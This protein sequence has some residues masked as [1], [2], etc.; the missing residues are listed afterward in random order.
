M[1][2]ATDSLLW[3]WATQLFENVNNDHCRIVAAGTLLIV[4]RE[5]KLRTIESLSTP[6]LWTRCCFKMCLQPPHGFSVA[7]LC[8]LQYQ[9]S[10][11]ELLLTPFPI[12][13]LLPLRGDAGIVLSK[14][15]IDLHLAMCHFCWHRFG[16][17]AKCKRGPSETSQAS[18]GRSLI[19][20][21]K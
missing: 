3:L 7:V 13:Y 11:P 19:R 18:Y 4:S 14:G 8:A 17:T 20:V 12:L 5:D 10:R 6:A 15:N 16:W 1:R 21:P 9:W 2:T